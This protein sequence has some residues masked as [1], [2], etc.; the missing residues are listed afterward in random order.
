[1]PLIFSYGTLQ[2]HN[3]QMSTLGRLLNGEKDELVGFEHSL[4][5]IKDPEQRAA[6]GKTHHA[7]VCFNGDP[8][9]RVAG[10]VFEIS[11]AEL[12]AADEYEQPARYHR[13]CTTLASGKE[14]WVYVHAG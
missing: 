5:E 11:E 1:M 13:I 12:A 2:Q 6:T 7:N 14:T 4:V 8:A 10:T 9:C 3:V